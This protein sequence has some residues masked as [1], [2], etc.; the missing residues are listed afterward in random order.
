MS[1]A[2]DAVLA[3]YRRGEI[4]APVAVAG[5]LLAGRLDAAEGELA[6]LAERHA[7]SMPGL[8]ALAADAMH[9]DPSLDGTRALFDRLAREAP[10]A[11]VALYT[12]GDPGLLDAAT[13]ELVSVIST[14]AEIGGRDLLDFGCGIGRVA[15]AL[16]PLAG[17]VLGVD[18]APAM[19][20]EAERRHAR[21]PG[22][23]FA[24]SDGRGL[25]GVTAESINCMIAADSFPYLVQAGGGLLER[26]LAEAAR[27]LRP[28]GDLLV[29]NWSYR[30]DVTAD[31]AE[32]RALGGAHGFD[33]LR[34]G[35]RPFALWDGVGFH[36]RRR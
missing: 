35:E 5:L 8:A 36:L 13:A 20:A 4:S 22:L 6:A 17:S 26:H 10:E 18:V 25:G 29:F 28:A 21:V 27:V 3:R 24:V 7:G 33:L 32:A 19:V 1:D 16:A 34:A 2:A 11:A 14:W 30:G 12:L 23:R 9:A 15:A 31:V